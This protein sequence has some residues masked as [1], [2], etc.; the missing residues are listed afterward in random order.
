MISTSAVMPG[1]SPSGT[2]SSFTI[3]SKYLTSVRQLNVVIG[4]IDVTWP[5]SGRLPI[6]VDLD[7]GSHRRI[8]LVDDRL[9]DHRHNFHLRKV[10][11]EKE[12]L[13]LVAPTS[14]AR[15]KLG[16]RIVGVDH[17]AVMRCTDRAVIDL[18]LEQGKPF[19]MARKPKRLVVKRRL[20][21]RHRAP[22]DLDRLRAPCTF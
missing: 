3:P 4:E 5:S 12:L 21:R 13:P 7:V 16:G 10:R 20:G 15:C 1:L 8:H 6:A 17:E 22:Q 18:F 11:Q 2:F 9:M 14:P 19:A